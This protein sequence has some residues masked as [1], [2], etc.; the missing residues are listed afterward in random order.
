MK[1]KKLSIDTKKVYQLLI[2][3]TRYAMTRFNHLEPVSTFN[4]ILELLPQLYK[5]D[6]ETAIATAK[7]LCE[8]IITNLQYN[9][10]NGFDDEFGNRNSYLDTILWLL[11]FIVDNSGEWKPY[12]WDTYTRQLMLDCEKRFEIYDLD[13]DEWE[14]NGKLLSK[15]EIIDYIIKE[16]LKTDNATY[17]KENIKVQ[18]RII[19]WKFHF[20]T[21]IEKNIRVIRRP[22][23]KR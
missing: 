12:N 14:H 9:Y 11:D 22:M 4:T 21:P 23:F 6:N 2:T 5:K 19:G 7:Q 13:N 15:K 1:T 8:E 17:N 16:V 18:D 3:S 20:K 10:E